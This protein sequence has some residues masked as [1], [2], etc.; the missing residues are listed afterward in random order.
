M[1]HVSGEAIGHLEKSL[2]HVKFS[3]SATSVSKTSQC[4]M[5]AL[6]KSHLIISRSSKKSEY[7][8]DLFSRISVD[9]I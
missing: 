1:A 7:D 8:D 6:I 2:A 5:C 4:E 9:L 3:D